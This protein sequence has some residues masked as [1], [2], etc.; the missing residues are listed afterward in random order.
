MTMSFRSSKKMLSERKSVNREMYS[1]P[2]RT[3]TAFF[4]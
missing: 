2:S 4:L 1:S 3:T